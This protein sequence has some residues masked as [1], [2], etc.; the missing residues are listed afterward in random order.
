MM[1]EQWI[2]SLTAK[3]RRFKE[4][5]KGTEKLWTPDS[6]VGGEIGVKNV[7][8]NTKRDQ[9]KRKKKEKRTEQK[10][11]ESKMLKKYNS[12]KEKFCTLDHTTRAWPRILFIFVHVQLFPFNTIFQ[13]LFPRFRLAF[14]PT[15]YKFIVRAF[16]S[17]VHFYFGFKSKPVL[18]EFK[19]KLSWV[20]PKFFQ[21][22]TLLLF[23][24]KINK[25]NLGFFNN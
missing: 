23:F 4:G 19:H 24:K 15:L 13:Y 10:E 11:K 8:Y 5:R 9:K 7:V 2:S 20:S 1:P 18:T 21:K 25:D 3:S 16:W 14:S 17:W 6:H 22:F 12:K